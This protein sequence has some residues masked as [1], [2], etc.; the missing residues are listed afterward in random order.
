MGVINVESCAADIYVRR[1]PISEIPQDS[2]EAMSK[3]LVDLFK[4]KVL[5]ST[6]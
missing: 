5:A 3:W 6:K 1:Y 2:D 4:E